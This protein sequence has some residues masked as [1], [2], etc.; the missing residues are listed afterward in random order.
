MF[1]FTH[2]AIAEARLQHA[3]PYLATLHPQYVKLKSYFTFLREQCLSSF[4]QYTYM[5]TTMRFLLFFS[6]KKRV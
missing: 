2:P 5:L 4:M 1:I 3:A 6:P